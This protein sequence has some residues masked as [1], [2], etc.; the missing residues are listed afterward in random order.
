MLMK[1]AITENALHA[2]VPSMAHISPGREEVVR[3]RG[4][5]DGERKST[6]E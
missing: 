6:S 5:R 4:G 2:K 3:T 1:T